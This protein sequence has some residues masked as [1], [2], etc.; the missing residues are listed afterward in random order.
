MYKRCAIAVLLFG[1]SSLIVLGQ[2]P[3]AL[4][5]F[6]SPDANFQFIYPQNYQLLTGERI[7]KA[8]QGRHVGIPVCDFSTAMVCLIYPVERDDDTRF[9]AAGLSV[10]VAGAASESECLSFA[11]HAPPSPGEQLRTTAVAINNHVYRHVA[12]RKTIT[13][14]SQAADFYRTFHRQKCYEVQIGVSLT[15][16]PTALRRA[17]QSNSLGD[18]VADSARDSMRLILS[19]VVFQQP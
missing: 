16:E 14:H 5:I 18:P 10:E 4:E 6:T 9:E 12:I 3:P 13:G 15:D 17:S 8:T 2:D 11:D 7:L 1:L 19:S